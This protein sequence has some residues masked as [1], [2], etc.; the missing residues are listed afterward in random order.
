VAFALGLKRKDA[1]E[2][3]ETLSVKERLEKVSKAEVERVKRNIDEFIKAVDKAIREEKAEAEKANK[4]YTCS[5]HAHA[6]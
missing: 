4:K 1:Q 3:L 6:L 2:F 5:K